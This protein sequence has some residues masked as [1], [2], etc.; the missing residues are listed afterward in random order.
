MLTFEVP[1]ARVR[2]GKQVGFAEMVPP[3]IPARVHPMAGTLA[4]A[5]R[6]V[7]AVE[8]GEVRDFTDAALRMRVSQTRVSMMVARTFLAPALQEALLLGTAPRLNTK[9]WLKIARM[10]TWREQ[11]EAV[12]ALVRRE[13]V[14][15]QKSGMHNPEAS[16]GPNSAPTGSRKAKISSQK[17]EH[18]SVEPA[19]ETLGSRPPFRRSS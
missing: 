13:S 7:R 5:H 14:S 8:S 11:I 3:P 16:R 19:L 9:Q 17:G 6:V 12:A 4:M 18:G 10:G 2:R 1:L 15:G